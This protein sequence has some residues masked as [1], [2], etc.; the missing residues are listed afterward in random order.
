MYNR[1]EQQELICPS[2]YSIGQ[3]FNVLRKLWYGYLRAIE[4]VDIVKMIKYAKAI[5]DVQRDMGI[6]DR[7]NSSA[8][9]VWRCF[10]R[11]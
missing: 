2:G 8:W 3:C 4:K 10:N 7:I 6:K 9:S 5:Q 11:K 1:K